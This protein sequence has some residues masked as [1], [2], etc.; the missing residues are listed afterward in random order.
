V[1]RS[2]RPVFNG[3]PVLFQPRSF[4]GPGNWLGKKIELRPDGY[5]FSALARVNLNRA[6]GHYPLA[7]GDDT[8]DIAVI[9]RAD[10]P[11]R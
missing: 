5:A 4:S 9:R 10:V 6:P 8:V 7:L 1:R 11:L 3:A 2:P